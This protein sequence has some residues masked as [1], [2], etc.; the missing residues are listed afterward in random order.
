MGWRLKARTAGGPKQPFQGLLTK[1]EGPALQD[2]D[3]C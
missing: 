2:Q 1:C 3:S